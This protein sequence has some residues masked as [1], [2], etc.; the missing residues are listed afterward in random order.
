M[1]ILTIA[2]TEASFAAFRA[3]LQPQGHAFLFCSGVGEA[4]KSA[5]DRR[6][7]LTVVHD[8]APFHAAGF[9]RALRQSG[10][11]EPV[12]IINDRDDQAARIEAFT[13]G[14][15]QVCHANITAEEFVA[16]TNAMFRQ[17]DP[18]TADELRYRD[19]VLDLTRVRLTRG[20]DVLVLSGKPMVLLE[21]LLRH[22]DKLIDRNDPGHGGL[23]RR[24]RSGVEKLR[25]HALQAPIG[26]GSGLRNA[27]SPHGQR[28]WLLVDGPSATDLTEALRSG[29]P[30]P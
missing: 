12:L 30:K 23:G 15:D 28:T 20:D 4:W 11:I 27:L 16:R 7:H 26:G 17:C 19:L 29:G 25:G 1:L 6:Q 8:D 2:Q 5:M 24:L 13:A 3:A 9:V 18:T 21:Y 22:P 10:F 14:A